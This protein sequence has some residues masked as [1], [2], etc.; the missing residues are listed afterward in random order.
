M[1]IFP[2]FIFNISGGNSV[3]GENLLQVIWEIRFLVKYVQNT[4]NYFLELGKKME[5]EILENIS[6][7]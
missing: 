1:K 5:V 4:R 3:R 2:A 6:W 7:R